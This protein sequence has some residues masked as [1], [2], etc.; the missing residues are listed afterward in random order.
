MLSIKDVKVKV[1]VR[2]WRLAIVGSSDP[3]L[4]LEQQRCLPAKAES[5]FLN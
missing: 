1:D 2:G 5:E 4:G 3:Q